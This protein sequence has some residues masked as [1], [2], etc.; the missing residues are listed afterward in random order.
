V[1]EHDASTLI[2][3]LAHGDGESLEPLMERW[4]DP[5]LETCFRAVR[6]P[7][8]AFDL[9]AEVCAEAYVRLR[10]GT[11]RRPAAFGPWAVEMI[12]DVLAVAASEGRIPIRAR[13][14]MKLAPVRFSGTDIERLDAL[15]D[16][17][18]LHD[19]RDRLPRDFSAAAD[20]MLLD[21]PSPAVMSRIRTSPGDASQ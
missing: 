6:D 2:W 1:Q 13:T 18:T 15:R 4:G 14:R 5:L 20:R 12:G 10:C 19:A 11:V 3:R 7:V 21:V 9:Y 17:Q 16:P 8:L